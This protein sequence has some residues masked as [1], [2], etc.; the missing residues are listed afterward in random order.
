MVVLDNLVNSS[1]VAIE[2]VRSSFPRAASRLD[3]VEGDIR[4]ADDLDRAFGDRD[5]DAVVHFAGLKAVGESVDEPLRYYENNVAGTVQLLER[6]NVTA[7]ETSCSPRRAPST[8]S[9]TRVPI[10]EDMPL[11]ATSPYGRTKLHIED[12]LRDLAA[13]GALAYGAAALLQPGRR[14]PERPHRRGPDRH[15]QQPDAVH[16]A[17]RRSAGATTSRCSA[18]TTPPPTAPAYATTCTS[19][20]W[21]KGTSRRSTVSTTSRRGRRS[22]SA[23]GSGSSVLEVVRAAEPRSD[24][25]IPYEIGA[26]RAGDVVAARPT[27]RSPGAPR[28]ARVAHSRRHVRRP[29]AL[30]VGQPRRVPAPVELAWLTETRRRSPRPLWSQRVAAHLPTLHLVPDSEAEVSALGADERSGGRR[31]ATLILTTAEQLF[32]ERGIAAVP[33]A[34]SG[35][36]PDRE[37]RGRP[38]PLR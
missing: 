24:A 14:A 12:M 18:T 1:E 5:V 28:L 22:T 32:A 3:F 37:Q 38:V 21:P 20:T 8:A 27:R 4:D 10:T 6:W 26:R 33:F 9:P 36:R 29:L 19:S 16:H 30:A 7:C 34:T 35:S 2:R 11:G 13:T 17:G 25:T 15:P 23:P 31:P